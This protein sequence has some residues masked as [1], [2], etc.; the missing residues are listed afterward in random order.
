[1]N[2]QS[3]AAV[4]IHNDVPGGGIKYHVENV[5]FPVHRL[6]LW[7]QQ[8]GIWPVE[9]TAVVAIQEGSSLMDL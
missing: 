9:Y 1:M 8:N 7:G 6:G 3:V 5:T 4:H 2:T